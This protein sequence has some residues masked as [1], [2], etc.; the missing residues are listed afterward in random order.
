LIVAQRPLCPTKLLGDLSHS[1]IEGGIDVLARGFTALPHFI[2]R[3]P[4]R[5]VTTQR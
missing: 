2:G 5:M 4:I 1:R 3:P